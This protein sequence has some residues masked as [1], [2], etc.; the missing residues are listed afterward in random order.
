LA[1]RIHSLLFWIFATLVVTA[2]MFFGGNRPAPWSALALVTAGVLIGSGAASALSSR[3]CSS[4]SVEFWV[5]AALFAVAPVWALV[6][7]GPFTPINWHNALWRQA[8][9]VLGSQKVQGLISLDPASTETAIMRLLTYGGVF[10]LALHFGQDH[11]SRRRSIH[12]IAIAGLLYAVYGLGLYFSGNEMVLWVK[13]VAYLGDVTSTFYNKNSYATYAG[14]GLL[15]AVGLLLTTPF[16]NGATP[17]E[18]SRW[19][20]CRYGWRATSAI[21]LTAALV[22][23]HSRAG[24]VC[25]GLGLMA[26]LV[27]VGISTTLSPRYILT[28]S[29][30]VLAVAGLIFVLLGGRT[31]EGLATIGIL[32][33]SGGLE[34][35]LQVYRLVMH[36]IKDVS[37]LGTGYGT[38]ADAFRPYQ[39]TVVEG[40]WDHAHNTYLENAMELG[41]PATLVLIAAIGGVIGGCA[42][43]LRC[44]VPDALYPCL[45]L[46]A[47]V[48]VGTH[49]LFDFSLEMPGIAITYAAI[50]GTAC[51]KSW[52]T[53]GSTA[54][55]NGW[56][57]WGSGD[58]ACAHSEGQSTRILALRHALMRVRGDRS[59]VLAGVVG[60]ALLGLAVPHSI[61]AFL[62]LPAD[63]T[64]AAVPKGQI[65]APDEIDAYI[66]R[67]KVAASW[68]D[69][70][71]FWAN[72][73][74]AN[75]NRLSSR[76]YN[77]EGAHT[78]ANEAIAALEHS[79]Q[80]KPSDP[81][82]WAKL[83]EMYFQLHRDPVAIGKALKLSLLTGPA[84]WNLVLPRCR[85]A[86]F[87]WPDLDEDLRLRFGQQFVMATARFGASFANL[88]LRLDR[89]QAVR[90]SLA[91]DQ[92]QQHRF[93]A[94]VAH[95]RRK[96]G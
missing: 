91:I 60:L 25:A 63:P 61:A 43:G 95:L 73:A 52:S 38:F 87:A 88:A 54:L 57:Q 83:A 75:F 48:Q 5:L 79:L 15:C 40:F 58:M 78:L 62:T 35:R 33:P 67:Q 80:R 34:T 66:S 65:R 14:L 81:Y 53:Q 72:I 36:A 3:P 90:E 19:V 47:T 10:Y 23:T 85:L 27:L 32:Q 26:L 39:S 12:A 18:Q 4:A 69:D 68:I 42:K 71:R 7:M 77:P 59:P 13:K 28:S 94:I 93:E 50:L 64:S 44:R 11:T 16:E 17:G 84:E 2:P 21:G 89:V 9:D 31:A 29:S 41:V 6:Q 8:A 74:R 86:L 82:I 56:S 70:G 76:T 46:A 92:D 45:G 55:A 22:L 37:L 96:S 49:A 24:F 20:L 51:A 1:V 30:V